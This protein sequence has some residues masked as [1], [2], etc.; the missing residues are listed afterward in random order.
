MYALVEIKGKQYKAQK[1]STLK[2]DKIDTNAGEPV[3]FEK[4]MMINDDGDIKLGSPY[5]KGVKVK[6]TLEEHGR[7]RKTVIY[8]FKRR[9]RYRKK[10]G[11]RQHYSVVKIEDIV[12]A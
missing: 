1:G 10:Q 11:H 4:V 5:L 12:E 8:K 3:E 2:V 9:K 7:D 6:A